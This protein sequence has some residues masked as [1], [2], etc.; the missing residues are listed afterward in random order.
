MQFTNPFPSLLGMG[1]NQ[2]DPY[3]SLLGEY[4]DPRQ[5][6]MAWIGGTLQGLGAGLASG[7]SGAWAEGLALGGGEG[8]DNYR[9][10]AVAGYALQQRKDEQ[11]W[12]RQQREQEAAAKKAEEDAQAAAIAGLPP[13]MRQMAQA[14]PSAVI[15]S[16][17]KQKYFPDPVDSWRYASTE[18]KQQLGVAPDA[19]LVITKSG[20]K[21]ISTGAPTINVMPSGEPS[22]DKLRTELS[23]NEGK[24]WSDYQTGSDTSGGLV[25]DLQ[26]IDELAK[27]APQGPLTGRFTQAFPGFSSAG[28]AYQSA[29][30]RI[31]PSLRQPGSGATSDIEYEG[32]LASLPSLSNKPEANAVISAVLQRKAQINIQR[33]DIVNKYQNGEISAVEARKQLGELNRKSIL[34]AQMKSLI[35]ATGGSG[36][37]VD[38][39]MKLYPPQ[40]QE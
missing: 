38:D 17:V 16:Y 8:L 23:K 11:D 21:L 37:S 3:Q 22:D 15:P 35:S 39:V 27:I 20:P 31:A 9:Q 24:T 1:S 12:Q 7:K 14:F 34:D 29:I 25:Q 10:R 4:Y 6:R 33:G 26:I 28:A 19:P 18:E 13:E 30:K 32:F 5:A 36:A 40:Q 2:P